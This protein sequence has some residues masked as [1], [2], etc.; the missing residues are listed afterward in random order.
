MKKRLI[1]FIFS[2]LFTSGVLAHE[3]PAYPILVDR[4]VGS[5][6]VSVWADPDTG[7]G[8]FD[9]Y[10]EG[11]PALSH[12]GA[13]SVTVSAKAADHQGPQL[14]GEAELIKSEPGRLSYRTVLAFD[15]DVMWNVEFLFKQNNRTE[16]SI[17]LPVEVTPP[18]P[19]RW[20]FALFFLPFLIVG[21]IWVRVLLARRNLPR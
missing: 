18:G 17:S 9:I 16:Q 11:N 10:V 1:T 5:L 21:F 4:L 8:T 6:K 14:T 20:E 19:N 2:L 13:L 12:T 3:G 15:R 7:S